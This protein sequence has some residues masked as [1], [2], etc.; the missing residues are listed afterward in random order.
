MKLRVYQ[1][2]QMM[3]ALGPGLRYG[4]WVPGCLRRCEGCASPMAQPLK[5]GE[6]M[7]VRELAEEILKVQQIEGITVSGGEP[8][9]QADALYALF[10]ILKSRRDIGV[11]L[12]TGC[13]YEE[14]A[15]RELLKWCDVLIDGEYMEVL[16]D[17]KSLRGSSNQRIFYLS[18]RYK[19]CLDFGVSSRD[20]EF[21]K[22]TDGHIVLVGIPS[23][24]DI[25]MVRK[26]KNF[27][28]EGD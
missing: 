12:Y 9:L 11:L 15:E 23:G 22:N 16:D 17:G 2:V 1:R 24:K 26:I 18:D 5:G 13:K 4:L 10:S 27:F 3:Q 25:E 19:S 20:I 6:L 14:I 21:V 8:L 7:D 28:E